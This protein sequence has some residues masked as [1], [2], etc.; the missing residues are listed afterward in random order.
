MTET[1]T[2]DRWLKEDNPDIFLILHALTGDADALARLEHE[3]AAWRCS[4]SPWP[5]TGRRWPRS[6]KGATWNWTTF[7]AWRTT[8]SK[9]AG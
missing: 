6:R 1:D 9:A 7:T 3:G 4:H 8:A 2:D 5:A